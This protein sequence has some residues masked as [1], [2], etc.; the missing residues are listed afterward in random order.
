MLAAVAYTDQL[1]ASA[2]VIAFPN[3]P[4]VSHDFW[5]RPRGNEKVAPEPF[6]VV[7]S[8]GTRVTLVPR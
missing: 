4:G 7:P 8:P 3:V 2:T 5:G 6:A 1:A